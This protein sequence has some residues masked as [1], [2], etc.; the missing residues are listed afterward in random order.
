MFLY[1]FYM[2]LYVFYMFFIGFYMFVMGG[3]FLEASLRRLP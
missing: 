1:V 3:S 2:F